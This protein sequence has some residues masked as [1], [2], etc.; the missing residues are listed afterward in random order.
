MGLEGIAWGYVAE[1]Y[2]TSSLYSLY[3]GLHKNFR[4]L[5]LYNP[6]KIE[7]AKVYSMFKD[8]LAVGLPM[9]LHLGSETV[10]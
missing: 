1:S 7:F 2:L 4:R 6:C 10:I 9:F 5:E 8:V 3:V